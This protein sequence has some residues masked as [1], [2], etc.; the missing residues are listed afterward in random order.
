MR[1]LS[2][3]QKNMKKSQQQQK[4]L[5]DKMKS[6]GEKEGNKDG[7]LN[8]KER[9]YLKSLQNEQAEIMT[10]LKKQQQLLEDLINSQKDSGLGQQKNII[11][12]LIKDLNRV[13]QQ[14]SLIDS[15]ESIKKQLEVTRN[16]SKKFLNIET[17]QSFNKV[18]NPSKQREAKKPQKKYN[19]PHDRKI[20]PKKQKEHSIVDT[21]ELSTSEKV[22]Y[23]QYQNL[24]KED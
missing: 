10:S 20:S 15:R 13:N 23:E 8:Q 21:S 22:F 5:L 4:R 6:L 17:K 19:I 14:L 16:T 18:N 9:K 3:Q 1:T 7:T 24:L 2:S 11:D 12:K